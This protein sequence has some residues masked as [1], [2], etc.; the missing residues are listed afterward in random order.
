MRA[1]LFSPGVPAE[2]ELPSSE[3]LAALVTSLRR[4]LADAV[5]ELAR[6]REPTL[7]LKTS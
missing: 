3:V 7:S 2:Q 4:E 6:A 1:L 5:R